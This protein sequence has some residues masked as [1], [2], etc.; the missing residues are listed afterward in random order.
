MRE[1]LL[2]HRIL[3]V[4]TIGTR[5]PRLDGVTLRRG[6][7]KLRQWF[8]S[9][10]EQKPTNGATNPSVLCPKMWPWFR[11]SFD[12]W[13][14]RRL[15]LRH[16]RPMVETL[17]Q[18][19]IAV[20]T[21]PIVAD[22]MD[23]LPVQQ[24][25][26]YCVDD[27][28]QWPG[29][30]GEALIR[31]EQGLLAKA[32]TVVACSRRLQEK[33]HHQGKEA[34]LLTHGVDVDFWQRGSEDALP[35]G[36][37]DLPRPRLLF[38]GLIDRRLDVEWVQRLGNDLQSGTIIFAGPEENPEPIL[39]HLPHVVRLGPLPLQVLPALAQA[40]DVLMMPYVDQPVTQA[41]Q[42]LKLLEYLATGKSV[43]V[44]DLPANR[45]WADCLDLATTSADF[46][47]LVQLR[48]TTGLPEEQRR[49]RQRLAA[50]SWQAKA[51]QFSQWLLPR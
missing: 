43:V 38:W 11:T 29:L 37:A 7:D 50:E 27:L 31:M 41:M 19:P 34:L 18:P 21:L 23:D 26:Y 49:A 36:V 24:W 1:L 8:F 20:T 25:V 40:A 42:P 51:Q 6:F 12:R 9:P 17:P 15:L 2:R 46:S 39:W 14:N 30:D 4:N 32:R 5:P 47:R 44:R 48:L 33:L 16:L 3:W 28:G 10:H 13:L 35:S 22:F 45:E